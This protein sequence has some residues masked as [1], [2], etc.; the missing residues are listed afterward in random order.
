MK[1][2]VHPLIDFTSLQSIPVL[3]EPTAEQATGSFQDRDTTNELECHPIDLPLVPR[4]EPLLRFGSPSAPCATES[5]S[6]SRKHRRKTLGF[7][8]RHGICLFPYLS[9]FRD[10]HPRDGF[11][12]LSR[13]RFISPDWRSWGY[14]FRAF[15]SQPAVTLLSVL[16]PSWRCDG[17]TAVVDFRA[18]L[19][20]R[21][22]RCTIASP[23][24]LCTPML[25]WVYVPSGLSP[26]LPGSRLRGPS[27]PLSRPHEIPERL[28]P[29]TWA[30]LRDT[31]FG[32]I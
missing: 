21:V 7:S 26:R 11:L 14:P 24:S 5:F 22:R 20:L 30:E 17:E 27:S 1:S 13:C 18:L 4:A 16:M 25:S 9:V 31:S 12:L 32:A 6:R 28:S 3:E 2:K 15:P 23:L 8:Q 29:V 19:Q 10:S